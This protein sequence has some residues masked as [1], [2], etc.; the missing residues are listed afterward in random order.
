[1][2]PPITHNELV[3]KYFEHWKTKRSDLTWAWDQVTDTI[4]SRPLDAWPLVLE[5][6]RAAPNDAAV[7]YVAAGPLEDFLSKHGASFLAPLA[8]AVES[9]PRMKQALRGVWGKNR[10]KPGVWSEIQRLRGRDEKSG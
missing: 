5:L 2:V 1:M 9:E 7:S 6:L 4:L 10:M 8:S 3:N